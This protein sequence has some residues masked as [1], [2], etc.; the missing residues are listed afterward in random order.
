MSAVQGTCPEAEAG[1]EWLG[2]EQALR[3]GEWGGLCAL[4]GGSLSSEE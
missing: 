2:T 4:G 1:H 3:L